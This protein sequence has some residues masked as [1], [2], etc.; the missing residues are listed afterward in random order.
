M[1]FVLKKK[2]F[3]MRKFG[4]LMLK[5]AKEADMYKKGKLKILD[6]KEPNKIDIHVCSI[7]GTE[8][9]ILTF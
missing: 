2:G 8:Q 1:N 6:E 4:R 7:D 5:T 9:R 3:K